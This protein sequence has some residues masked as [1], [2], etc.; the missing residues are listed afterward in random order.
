MEICRDVTFDEESTL[1][2]SRICQHEEFYEED[3]PPINVEATFLSEDEEPK[4]HDM[5]EPQEPPWEIES[6]LGQEKLYKKQ[7]DMELL[8]A[9]QG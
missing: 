1:K 8:K 5:T 4:D 2:R 9:P 3:A 6:L 7:K